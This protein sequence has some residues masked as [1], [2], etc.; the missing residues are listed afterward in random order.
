MPSAIVVGGGIAGLVMARDLVLGGLDVT[1]LEASDHL[2][3]KIARHTVAGVDLDAGAESFASSS[4][5]LDV[6]Y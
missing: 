6:M 4:F 3:G 5:H 2:G 1:L